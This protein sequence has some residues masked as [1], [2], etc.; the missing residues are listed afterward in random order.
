[1]LA[2]LL[3]AGLLAAAQAPDGNR[4]YNGRA[5]EIE[6]TIPR[7]EAEVEIDGA[8]DEAVW[9][10][11]ALLTGFSQYQPVDGQPAQDS[12][13]VLVWYD[14]YAIYFGVR[15]F[16][17]HVDV[18]ATLA[19]RDRIDAEDYIQILL[20]PFN[21]RRRAWIFGVNPL[22]VQA[23][24]VRAEAGGGAS[25]PGAGGRFE[26]VDLNPDFVYESR[27]HVTEWGYQIELRIPFKSIPF[28]S[29]DVQS[30]AVNV[31]R[32]VQHSGYDDTWTPTRRASASFL[33]QSGT[34]N[35]LTA[36]RRGLVLDVNP[37]AATKVEGTPAAAG[38]W[39]Y[40]TTPDV[41]GNVRWG[42]TTNLTLDA[43]INPDFSQ[44]EA[45]AGQ[46]TVNERFALF[47]AE[48]RPFFLE[49]I[50]NFNTPNQLIYTRQIVNPAAGAKLT[51]K[52]GGTTIAYLA[53]V[54]DADFS[55]SGEDRPV[56]NL[57]RLRRDLG[58]SST[59]GMSYTDRTETGDAF[60][61]VVAADARIVFAQ[62]YFLQVQAATSFTGAEGD[63]RIGPLWEVTADRTGRRWGFNYSL[64]GMHPEFRTSSGFVPRT[65][66]VTPRIFNRLSFYG[67][68]DALVE[69][70]TTFY[71]LNGTWD[72]DEFFAGQAPLETE[73]SARSFVTMRGGWG[74]TVAPSWRTA[75]FDP[76][77][78]SGYRVARHIDAGSGSFT[79]TVA[80][81]VPD[82]VTDAFGVE[83]SVNT[84]QFP[85]FSASAGIGLGSDIA[86]FEPSRVTGANISGSVLWRPTERARIE[87]SYSN[88]VL[89][90]IRDGSRFST[91]RIPRLKLEYQLAR[92]L[93]LRFVGQYRYQERAALR[94]P[95]T[96]QP[97][98]L[99][100]DSGLFVISQ[101][102][103]SNDLRVDWLL[104]YR[105]TPGTVVFLGYGSGFAGL[106]RH[107][108]GDLERQQDGFFV[109][110]SYL[111]RL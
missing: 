88:L 5:G 83:A 20:D 108:F 97:I 70:W 72:Y 110:V 82:R 34:L 13:Q 23:D 42:V 53:A 111:F 106:E 15:A 71:G 93:F 9:Q 27:G 10:R 54:D 73:A 29:D 109:K 91:A 60:N 22:G 56:F 35:G 67:A 30:W 45:D 62:L 14:S 107:S 69:N 86:F 90:R 96:D 12:T 16:E 99:Q 39:S 31:L 25:G 95:R 78:Y 8:L 46:V 44:V 47:F 76:D 49:G 61:R 65:G 89:N 26:N 52:I 68:P 92:P 33:A 77:F 75:S 19:D 87:G 18:S 37:F 84:P 104:S 55:A 32:K 51:G 57:L 103:T 11:A 80:F 24:G 1:M 63:T 94:D 105:P 43:T 102:V 21:D 2:T 64:T 79:D 28:P 50:E 74:V 85:R 17:S 4:A 7:A 66:I 6:V 101:P 100:D 40:E 38:G 98:L 58:A 81:V 36:L 41:G 48:K 3:T 59:L